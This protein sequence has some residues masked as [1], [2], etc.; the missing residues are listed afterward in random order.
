MDRVQSMFTN[1]YEM[2]SWDVSC[3]VEN[4]VLCEKS[5]TWSLKCLQQSVLDS[6]KEVQELTTKLNE[7]ETK[8]DLL[9]QNPSKILMLHLGMAIYL[10]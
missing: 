10:I 2:E 1:K 8:I 5:Q 3:E 7:A 6:K 9:L 4:W